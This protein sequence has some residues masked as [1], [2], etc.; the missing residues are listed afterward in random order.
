MTINPNNTVIEHQIADTTSTSELINTTIDE[1]RS[2]QISTKELF[3]ALEQRS[4]GGLIV[5]LSIIGLIPGV[6]IVAGIAII[7]LA[8]QL[9]SGSNS[10]RLPNSI[11]SREIH[12]GKLRSAIRRP[13][14]FISLLERV[15]KPR[16]PWMLGPAMTQVSGVIM[17]ILALVMITPLPLSNLLP[18]LALVPIALGLLERDGLATLLGWIAAIGAVTVGI[19]M[20]LLALD[21]TY[22]LFSR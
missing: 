11:M 15:I 4:F 17:I 14:R 1:L 6:S 7:I 20:I 9:I 18:A 16:W 21:F 19:F 2:E 22:W 8:I 10:P 12:S 5:L 13:L 3:N